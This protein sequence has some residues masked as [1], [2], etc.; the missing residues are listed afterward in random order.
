MI[1]GQMMFVV[2]VL[3]EISELSFGHTDFVVPLKPSNRDAGC[4]FGVQ[5]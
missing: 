1:W 2:C 3:Q 4:A 5:R